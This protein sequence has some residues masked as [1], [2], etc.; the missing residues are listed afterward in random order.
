[1]TAART[2]AG[3]GRPSRRNGIP[4]YY[5][6]MRDLKE[7]IIAGKLAP[8]HQLPSEAELTQRFAVSRVVVRQALQ[9]LDEQGLI[10]RV[11]GKGTF[12]SEEVA[13]DATPRISGSLEDLIHIGPDTSI[14]VVEFRLVK[15]TP[16][17]AEVFA[18]RG[19]QRP[20]P[21]PAR[22]PRRRPAARRAGEPRALRDRRLHLA[23]RSRTEPLIVLIEKRAGLQ[24]RVGVAGL[25][26]GR[27]RRGAG[28]AA[29][30]RPAHAAA[31]AHPDRLLDRRRVVDL[32]EVFYRSDRY[33]HHGFLA[34]NRETGGTFWDA[35]GRRRLRRA[36]AVRDA[37]GDRQSRDGSA[38]AWT[39]PD[40]GAVVSQTC[41]IR[42]SCRL[43]HE[44]DRDRMTGGLMSQAKLFFMPTRIVHGLG[45][46]STV[47][48]QVR[49]A[50]GTKAFVCT[51]KGLTAAG[52]TA[53]VTG[54][55]DEAELPYVLFDRGGGRPGVR[56]GRRRRRGVHGRGLRPRVA[57]GGGSP[58]CAGKGIALVAANGGV[59]TDYEGFN[60]AAR[61]RIR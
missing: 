33:K 5:Q 58:M 51:D 7:Q 4:L 14:Q 12:V 3:D 1:M 17:L 47:A 37:D 54:L 11:K 31:Q 21:R 22:P 32:A 40:D 20:L 53:R 56:D 34:R 60:K 41:L 2:E 49:G 28:A 44:Q 30:G 27:R 23:E 38:R 16:D 35:L 36:G 8:G 45:S 46:I 43:A 39:T 42:N 50:G 52:V 55:L 57:L 24:D 29:R 59:L 9:I 26:G 18:D 48:A 61:R 6:I 13:D 15:T 19:G 10:R 25:R